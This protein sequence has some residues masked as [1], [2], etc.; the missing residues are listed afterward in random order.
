VFSGLRGDVEQVQ[1]H[2]RKI[3]HFSGAHRPVLQAK[4]CA[5]VA[6]FILAQHT[7]MGKIYTKWPQNVPKLPDLSWRNKPKW[8]KIYHMTL[9]Y[10]KWP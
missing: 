10:T 9:K 5:R 4:V 6:R 8:G 1:L 7:K 3:E 2:V